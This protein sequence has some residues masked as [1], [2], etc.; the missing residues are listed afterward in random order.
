MGLSA[1]FAAQPDVRSRGA[2]YAAKAKAG[3]KDDLEHICIENI[4]ACI[5][6]GNTCRGDDDADAESLYFALANRM[7][8]ILKLGQCD[9]RDDGVTRELKRRIW[10]SCFITDTWASGGSNLSPQFKWQE[11]RP[12]VPMDEAVFNEMKPGGPDI[13]DSEWRPGLWGHMVRLVQIYMQ[14][15]DLHRYLAETAE[16]N[17]DMMDDAVRDL[18]AELSAFDRSLEPR[19]HFSQEN[20]AAYVECGLGSVFIAFHLGYHHYYVLLFYLYLD[21]RRPSTRNGRAYSDRCK[22]HATI[23]CDVLKASRETPGAE[24]L[25][26]IVGHVTI[27][28]SSV[29]LHTYLF[30]E[31]HEIA[32]SRRGLESNFESLVQ[33]RRYWPSVEQMIN[34]LVIFQK[35]CMKSLG[36]NTYRF[37]KWMV[38]FLIAHALAMEDKEE[39]MSNPSPEYSTDEMAGTTHFERNRIA[40]GMIR[41]IRNPDNYD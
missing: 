13:P 14:I 3:L 39:N 25:Y 38:K 22:T 41:D 5:L 15:Q 2:A 27:V 6:V 23:V 33:L 31:T 7:A 17:E 21:Q 26:N 10:W 9:E 1:R 29:L 36:E 4:Q 11:S 35:S 18:D 20:L 30:G 32:D 40:Q 24:A 16:W 19:M 28:S 12:R 37:D 8:Q 34:R